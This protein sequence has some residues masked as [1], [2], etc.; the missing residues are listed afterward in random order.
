MSRLSRVISSIETRA[1]Q[2]IEGELPPE[3]K[4]RYMVDVLSSPWERDI[5]INHDLICRLQKGLISPEKY[6]KVVE[7]QVPDE[8]RR[9][10][11]NWV[12]SEKYDDM[13]GKRRVCHHLPPPPEHLPQL[14]DGY[15]KCVDRMLSD[16]NVDPIVC[17]TIAK[18]AF[19]VLHPLVDGNGRVQR[20]LFQLVLFK[21]GFL[22]RMNVP[23][24]VIMLQDRSGYEVLQQKHVDQTMAGCVFEEGESEVEEGG[25]DFRHIGATE[26]VTALYRY[27]DFTFAT[28]AMIKLMQ[29]TLP[30][31]AAKAYFL[32]RF[33]WRVDEL[34]KGDALLPARAATKIAKAFK[35]DSHGFSVLKLA[36]LFF[37]DGWQ[38]GFKRL[39]RFLAMAKHPSDLFGWQRVKRSIS[40]NYG[41]SKRRHWMMSSGQIS[42]ATAAGRVRWV[43]V[44][45]A[46]FDES[47][48]ALK[49][50]LADSEPQ[51]TVMA[52]HYP[53]D[54]N[55]YFSMDLFPDLAPS[56][57][58][59]MANIRN[60]VLSK[61]QGVADASGDA[62]R[63]VL[64]RAFVGAS[65]EYK[66][67]YSLCE[68]ARAAEVLPQC[69]YVGCVE[70]GMRRNFTDFIVRNAPCDVAIIKHEV[71]KD[72]VVRWVGISER[73]FDISGAALAKAFH[74]SKAGDSVVAVHYPVNPFEGE[75]FS[76]VYNEHFSSLAEQHVDTIVDSVNTR[77]L[78]RAQRIADDHRKDGVDFQLLTGRRTQEPH[79]AIVM[80]VQ[81]SLPRPSLIYVGY[82]QRRDR[83]RLVDP[84]K[85]YDVAEF[86]V[87]NAPCNVVVVKE[88]QEEFA[89]KLRHRKRADE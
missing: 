1:S 48:A 65:S 76:S 40:L 70:D 11:Q 52:V 59:D 8:P 15:F 42:A 53:T 5:Q 9:V 63:G 47:E 66:P 28:S 81:T 72:D 41:R 17:A 13:V 79:I 89:R 36:K 43:G 73:N 20:V 4:Q 57:Q 85:L 30:V 12:S 83:K 33:D 6:P 77:V 82:N 71:Q 61:V 7:S 84:H 46:K 2:M 18:I 26:G 19:N 31:I 80:D 64:F 10:N 62:Q 67:A 16:P 14:L 34:L 32:Q 75:G 60:A 55:T 58:D 88:T 3:K 23:V 87:K 45:L 86:V 44:S 39:F 49:Q 78:E 68:D 38:L 50:A 56:I 35:N 37:I 29:G 74:D 22:P 21:R 27:Q 24:S 25:V 51:D 54:V 69:I